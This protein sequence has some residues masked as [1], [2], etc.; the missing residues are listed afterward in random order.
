MAGIISTAFKAVKTKDG[1]Q[2][3]A[4]EQYKKFSPPYN[5]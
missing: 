3:E 2:K 4:G 5:I 1:L